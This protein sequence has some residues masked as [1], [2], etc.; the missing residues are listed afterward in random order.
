M[1]VRQ[2]VSDIQTYP[3]NEDKD[4][5]IADFLERLSTQNNTMNDSVSDQEEQEVEN[6]VHL[7]KIIQDSSNVKHNNDTP[8]RSSLYGDEMGSNS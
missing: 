1:D 5:T 3:M 2:H 6:Q 4:V 8:L 7:D